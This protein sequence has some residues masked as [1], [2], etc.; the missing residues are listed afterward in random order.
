M[1]EL[2]D[3]LMYSS[4]YSG[5]IEYY[6]Y[7]RESIKF[8]EEITDY[9]RKRNTQRSLYAY[10]ESLQEIESVTGVN[11]SR[12]IERCFWGLEDQ[13]LTT[14]ADK[15]AEAEEYLFKIEPTQINTMEML[16]EA[17]EMEKLAAETE[18]RNEIMLTQRDEDNGE[19]ESDWDEDTKAL[20]A[21]PESLIKLLKKKRGI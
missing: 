15:V 1:D 9:V 3:S 2:C 6:S 14:Y 17:E 5:F 19:E 8:D 11:F 10:I 13:Y 12:E 18:Q 4:E 7:V 16:F 20:L 21:D